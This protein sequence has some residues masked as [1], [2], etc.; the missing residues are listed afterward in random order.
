MSYP[1]CREHLDRAHRDG[2]IIGTP[3]YIAPEQFNGKEA[4]PATD[5]YALGVV[6]YECVTGQRPFSEEPRAKQSFASAKDLIRISSIHPR[7]PRRFDEVVC[8][9]LEYDPK[10][11]YQTAKEVERALRRHFFLS[12]AAAKTP[13]A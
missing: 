7:V 2:V 6:L 11:R 12:L 13:R 9:C 1:S 4:T 10:R 3:G 8:R 5:V